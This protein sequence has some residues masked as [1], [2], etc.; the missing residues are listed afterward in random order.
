MRAVALLCAQVTCGY[1]EG[2][3]KG[4]CAHLDVD[5]GPALEEIARH[6]HGHPQ[7]RVDYAAQ[8]L[9]L[10]FGEEAEGGGG[11]RTRWRS[12]SGEGAEQGSRCCLRRALLRGPEQTERAL[13]ATYQCEGVSLG[14][15]ISKHCLKTDSENARPAPAVGTHTTLVSPSGGV[16]LR[17]SS[18]LETCCAVSA[19]SCWHESGRDASSEPHK[20]RE[21]N[22][23]PVATVRLTRHRQ[24]RP[25]C[26]QLTERSRT[27]FVTHANFPST[28]NPRTYP[29][30]LA[31]LGNHHSS[32][33][34]VVRS[35][36]REIRRGVRHSR[37]APQLADG[38]HRI[39][40][41]PAL[42]LRT[43]K[44]VAKC[45]WNENGAASH[46]R[47]AGQQAAR[48]ETQCRGSIHS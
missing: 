24:N 46:F 5:C 43:F 23:S 9:R 29:N 10:L 38:T 39:L 42:R 31:L 18:C 33:R 17:R 3:C 12:G 44:V 40:H 32:S 14:T 25:C 30:V 36:C 48:A 11:E 28:P 34:S 35:G 19:R 1:A 8:V 47:G 7:Q 15:S 4:N 13:R 27:S 6:G 45:A 16:C 2:M 37:R 26:L 41:D 20:S 22:P 21:R